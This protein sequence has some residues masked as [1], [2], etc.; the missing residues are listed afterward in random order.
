MTR[1]G[2]TQTYITTAAG[3][4]GIYNYNIIIVFID[5]W[6]RMTTANHLI[7]DGIAVLITSLWIMTPTHRLQ[8]VDKTNKRISNEEE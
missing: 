8:L 7:M 2:D 1:I 6:P 4:K 3:W 5:L